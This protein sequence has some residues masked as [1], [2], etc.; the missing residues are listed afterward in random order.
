[1]SDPMMTV[2]LAT[3]NGAKTLQGVLDAYCKLDPPEG[4]WKLVI[5]DNG[6]TD[7]TR[8]IIISF[9]RYLPLSYVF[10]PKRGKNTALNTGLLAATGDLVVLT[11]DDILPQSDWLTQIRIAAD[12]H[13]SFSIFGG[14]IL[15]KWQ[16]GPEDWL[17]AWVKMGPTYA[18]TNPA[19]EE[20]PII[21]GYVFGAN[22]AIRAGV[23]RAGY[24]F[25]ESIGPQG[26][27]YPMGSET[28]LTQRLAKAGF[29]AWHC[30]RAIVEHIIRKHQMDRKWVLARAI[31]YG[32]G[33]MRLQMED[34]PDSLPFVAGIPRYLIRE[35]LTQAARVGRARL[36]G[37]AKTVFRERWELN[38]LVGCALESR[39]WRKEV[40]S[41]A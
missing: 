10:E 2:L 35:I 5:V 37:D 7:C 12:S 39:A 36:R 29:K 11:D 27:S 26:T 8:E 34:L 14:S 17:L 18:I 16:A 41:Q 28:E 24:R 31:P 13:P 25:N 40:Q 32:R 19:W 3:H 20:G 9:S 1:M 30:K 23:F 6:S 4:G 15:P 21:P 22:M 33:Q 38:F